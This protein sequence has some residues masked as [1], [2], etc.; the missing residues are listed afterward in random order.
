MKSKLIY[1]NFY[2]FIILLLII[3]YHCFDMKITLNFIPYL[4]LYQTHKTLVN[5]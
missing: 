4:I 2:N 5:S 3:Y 1:S